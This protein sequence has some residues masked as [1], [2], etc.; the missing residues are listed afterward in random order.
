MIDHKIPCDGSDAG[1]VEGASLVVF[2]RSGG[3]E[4]QRVSGERGC[5]QLGA[6]RRVGVSVCVFLGG[7]G[8]EGSLRG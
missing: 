1:Q 3:G 8:G 7:E 4:G 5:A 6:S 2:L